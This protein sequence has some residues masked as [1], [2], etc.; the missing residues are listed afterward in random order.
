MACAAAIAV[1]STLHDEGLVER[2]AHLGAYMAGKLQ[3]LIEKHPGKAVR[4]RGRGLMIGLE[5][6]GEGKPLLDACRELGLVANVT[7]GNVLRMLPPYVITE[8]EIDE[9]VGIIDAALHKL[10]AATAAD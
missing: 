5:V 3:A 2:A 9:A 7:A 10:P 8:G 4:V 1:L 6:A